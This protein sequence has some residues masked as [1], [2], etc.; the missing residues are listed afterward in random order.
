MFTSF[1]RV[2]KFGWQSFLRNKGLTLQV[3][4]IMTVTVLAVTSLFLFKG[5]SE[6][7]I[8][9]LQ[10]RVDISVYFKKDTSEDKIFEIKKELGQLSSKIQSVEYISREKAKEI[11]IQRHKNDPLYLQ[12]LKEIGENPFL[13]S[14]NIKAK[15]PVF[16][17]QISS[18][19]TKGPFKE[20]V[21]KVSYYQ[22]KKLIEKL[23]EL[24][25][26]IKK[27]GVILSTILAILVISITFNTIKLTIFSLKEE[28]S[29]MRL[30]GASNW[31]IRGPFLV[32]SLLYGIFAVM[33]VNLL[34]FGG[35]K[36]FNES[37]KS[38]MLG[39]DILN[40]FQSNLLTLILTQIVFS[41]LLGMTSFF[42][43]VRK[44]LKI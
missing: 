19:F 24:T 6:F 13:P 21:E 3:I 40:Y 23:I 25:S 27:I 35:L 8:A 36:I 38:W 18:F 32:Q 33:I 1:K 31:F 43:T 2:L 4:F 42:I 10:K 5:V 12:A 44:Y 34:V 39:F 9:E 16:Y 29:T 14:L 26:K 20:F 37:I 22:N 11:F 17:A 15:D 28:I 41:I 7:L 30:V